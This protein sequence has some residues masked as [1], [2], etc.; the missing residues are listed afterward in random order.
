MQDKTCERKNDPGCII[1]GILEGKNVIRS[2][3]YIVNHIGMSTYVDINKLT[4]NE[5][6][7][8]A[9]VFGSD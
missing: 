9:E 2:G 7:A 1:K 8:L 3:S 4:K 5:L 6:K